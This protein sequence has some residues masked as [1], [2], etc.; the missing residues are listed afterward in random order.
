MCRWPYEANQGLYVSCGRCMNCRI[1][2]SR[3]WVHRIMLE[4]RSHEKSCFV[5]LTY[6][7]EHIPKGANLAPED[8]QKFLKRLR[9]HAEPNRV[10]FYGVGEYGDLGRPHFH[11]CCFGVGG[12]DIQERL[13]KQPDGKTKLIRFLPELDKSWDNGLID[14]GEINR[15][16]ARYITGYITKGIVRSRRE[17]LQGRHPEFA[18]MS[19]RPGIGAISAEQIGELIAASGRHPGCS[20]KELRI[21]KHK[22]PLGKYLSEKVN[23][24]SGVGCVERDLEFWEWQKELYATALGARKDVRKYLLDSKESEAHAQVRRREL[25]SQRSLL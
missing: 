7:E 16:S 22:W 14:V 9:K 17:W 4:L 2:R 24:P 1:N 12:D 15:H 11:L 13:E 10:R 23:E 20:I 21:G 5:T 8:M 6:D 3:I 18:R 19:N 25:F